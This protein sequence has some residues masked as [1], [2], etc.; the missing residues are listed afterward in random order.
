[1]SHVDVLTVSDICSHN[2]NNPLSLHNNNLKN[3]V[4]TSTSPE[5]TKPF[6]FPNRSDIF[7]D[8]DARTDSSQILK[9]RNRQRESAFPVKHSN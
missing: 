7:Q 6:F 8:D 3:D 1:M 9:Q 4:M 5:Y 2:V